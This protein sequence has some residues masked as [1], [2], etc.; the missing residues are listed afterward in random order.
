[1]ENLNLYKETMEEFQVRRVRWVI[2]QL[3]LQNKVL[4]KWEIERLAGLRKNYSS[5]VYNEIIKGISS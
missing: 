4:R 3:K 2:K 5:L 1:M